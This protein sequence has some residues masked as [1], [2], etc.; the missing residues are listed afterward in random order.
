[1]IQD[2]QTSPV[3]IEIFS[4]LIVDR[5]FSES[6]GQAKKVKDAHS[7]VPK[8]YAST[9]G[10]QLVCLFQDHSL[11]SNSAPK[12]TKQDH[13]HIKLNQKWFHIFWRILMKS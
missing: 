6:V 12:T 9:L 3:L 11:Q 10:S 7:I 2:C 13:D 8:S 4:S 5:H 1:M